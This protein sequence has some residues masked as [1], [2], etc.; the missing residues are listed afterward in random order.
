MSVVSAIL[1]LLDV[2]VIQTRIRLGVSTMLVIPQPGMT[3]V[4]FHIHQEIR[5]DIRS[6]LSPSL[7]TCLL[8]TVHCMYYI[9]THIFFS[10]DLL[11]LNY[12]LAV[13]NPLYNQKKLEQCTSAKPFP[14][15][16]RPWLPLWLPHPRVASTRGLLE[17]YKSQV[18]TCLPLSCRTEEVSH[19]QKNKIK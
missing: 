12:T 5:M 3:V 2:A 8:S 17:E 4:Y 16:L 9:H 19:A 13:S 1:V 11:F 10:P 15:C 18:V 6:P 7:R 14:W